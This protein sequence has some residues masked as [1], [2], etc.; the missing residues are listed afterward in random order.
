MKLLTYNEIF[1]FDNLLKAHYSSRKNK[2]HKKEVIVYEENL[3]INIENLRRRLINRTYK[4]NSYNRFKIFE[5]KERNVASLSYEN[6]IVQHCFC[7]NYLTPLLDCRLINDNA[8]CRKNRGTD[9]ARD[10]VK[11]FLHVFFNKYN[12]NGYVLR[13]DIHHYFD[14]IDHFVLKDKIKPL[15]KDKIIMEFSEMIID[16]FNKDSG[17][18]LPLGNQTSQAY[19]LYYLD[20]V[21]RL[22]KEK[23]RIK[24]Y[25]RYM[26]D[27]VIIHDDLN[28]LKQLLKDIESLLTDLKLTLN[29]KTVIVPIKNKFSYLGI[30]YHLKENGKVIQTVTHKKKRRIIRYLKSDKSNKESL[31]SFN[32]YFSKYNEHFF[33]KKH[34]YKDNK[35]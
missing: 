23:Y 28:V 34:L 10:R 13:F 26:D 14:E 31:Q 8:A 1:T 16:S 4:I 5:P 15:I 35:K 2:R 12:L 24:Y 20:C 27:G 21:D 17:K 25:S 32:S 30:S 6:R 3:L 18:G 7:D 29:N 9:F 33:A 19:A 11:A 22:I